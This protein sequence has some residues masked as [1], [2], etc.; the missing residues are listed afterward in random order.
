MNSN[1]TEW[2]NVAKA[3]IKRRNHIK[4]LAEL[5]TQIYADKKRLY[6]TSKILVSRVVCI[7]QWEEGTS[8]YFNYEWIALT[9]I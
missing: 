9:I 7:V 1:V 2:L 3:S 5:K 8:I 6:I 4:P